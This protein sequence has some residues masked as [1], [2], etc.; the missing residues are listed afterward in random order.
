MSDYRGQLLQRVRR[1]LASDQERTAFEAHLGS[2]VDCRLAMDIADDFDQVEVANPEDGR[3]IEQIATAARKRCEHRA[4]PLAPP[5]A[6]R[7]TWTIALAALVLAGA[8]TAGALGWSRLKANAKQPSPAT[9][10]APGSPTAKPTGA[11]RPKG[12]AEPALAR[13]RRRFAR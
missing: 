3:L 4:V 1:G 2:C 5:I 9:L 11:V 10:P 12:S 8:A 6:P 13:R 7:L